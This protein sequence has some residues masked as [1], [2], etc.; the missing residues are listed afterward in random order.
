VPI[1][2]AARQGR[3]WG[4]F[5]PFQTSTLEQE[6]GTGPLGVH[7]AG[8]V[9]YWALVPFIVAGAL[10]LRRSRVTLLPMVPFFLVAIAAAAVAFGTY[11][12]RAPA[13]VPIAILAAAGIDRLWTRAAHRP[14]AVRNESTTSSTSASVMSV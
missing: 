3:I 12:Y 8:V 10:H 1:V 2:A 14:E 4:V 5:R 6:F 13:E 9:F 7:H 11:R